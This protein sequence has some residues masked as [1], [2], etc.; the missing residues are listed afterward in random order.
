M[1]RINPIGRVWRLARG[2][3]WPIPLLAVTLAVTAGLLLPVLDEALSTADEGSPLGFVFGGDP[4]AARDLLAAIAG[5]LISVTG[6]TFS[7]TV[8]ALQLGSSQYSPRLLQTFV[9]DPVVQGTLAQL[10]GTFVYALTVL[11]TVRTAE[12]TLDGRAFVPRLSIT[13]AF[14]FAL[15]SV[16][17]LVF[18]LGHLARML[19]VETMLRNVHDE[20]VATIERTD[21]NPDD[22][23]P[24]LPGRP[25]T[26]VEAQASGFVV[27][28]DEERLVAVARERDLVLVLRP[29]M[30]DS[31]VR[32][33][34]LAHVW[35]RDG[36]PVRDPDELADAVTQAVTLSYERTPEEDAAYSVRKI[37]DIAG[38]ALSPGIND[39]TTAVHALSHLS[40]LL[41]DL[42]PRH[43]PSLACRDTD[44]TLRLVVHRW[45][46]EELLRLGLEETI[47]YSSGQPAVLRRIAGLLRELAWRVR[48]HGLDRELT[49]LV[50]R[51]ARLAA[52]TTSVDER[53]ATLWRAAVDDALAGRWSV[54]PEPGR[55][56]ATP[57]APT[58]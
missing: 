50:E 5:S 36:G 53:E 9:T 24:E 51:A 16:A 23:P 42:L 18:F 57:H 37:V 20:A 26:P 11:R 2:A 54:V 10:T 34:P 28:V 14:L 19:R 1:T 52:E 49:A 31:V 15:G 8:V 17:A 33:T 39:P 30:G 12:A 43:S 55:R 4:G 46:A 6:V 58:S 27:A 41:G 44:G 25:G 38:R 56:P 45:T 47:E 32:G 40:A 35:P 3:L 48:G 7:L 13:L 22:A 21:Q 29:R